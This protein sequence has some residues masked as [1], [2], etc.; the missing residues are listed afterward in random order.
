[1][2]HNLDKVTRNRKFEKKP[3]KK[4]QKINTQSQTVCEIYFVFIFTF[5]NVGSFR[6]V[7]KPSSQAEP[8]SHSKVQLSK[9]GQWKI[10][11]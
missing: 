9:R 7:S 8:V 5:A 11:C 3:K 10:I 6:F 1:M 2:W 4:K